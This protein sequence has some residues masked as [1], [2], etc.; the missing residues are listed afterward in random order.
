MKLTINKNATQF[1][2][3]LHTIFCVFLP[4]SFSHITSFQYFLMFSSFLFAQFAT[5]FLSLL[6]W[7]PHLWVRLMDAL[8]CDVITAT[9]LHICAC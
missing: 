9:W 2:L 3:F 7:H 8:E 1:S 4:H 6:I 5:S